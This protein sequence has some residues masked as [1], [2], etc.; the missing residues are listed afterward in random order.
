MLKPL[1]KADLQLIL[2]WRNAPA[3]RLAMF[4]QHKITF[5]E[6][7][8]WFEHLKED[9]SKRWLLYI[10]NDG[11]PNG[12][13]YFTEMHAAQASA[14]WGFYTNPRAKAGTGM[15]MSLNALDYAFNE[16]R[17]QKLNT[18][19]LASNPRSLR[20]QKNIGFIEE[21]RFRKQYFNGKERIDVIR[22]GILESEWRQ[23]RS[24]LKARIAA[25][26]LR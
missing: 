15:Q 2:Q 7:Q 9:S 21:G 4:S 14:F 24:V 23:C 12:V 25:L 17:I 10:N 8:R 3:V 5:G 19:V 13:V 22:L 26:Q 16:L 20:M 18:E 6:H 11:E 1:E